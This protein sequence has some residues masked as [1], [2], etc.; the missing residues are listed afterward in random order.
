MIDEREL[1]V[2]FEQAADDYD[3]P[4]DGPTRILAAAEAHAPKA[5][6]SQRRRLA[7]GFAVIV[8]VVGATVTIRQLTDQQERSKTAFS[9]AHSGQTAP[10]RPVSAPPSSGSGTAAAMPAGDQGASGGAAGSGGIAPGVANGLA[11]PAP[12]LVPQPST[13]STADSAK[14]VK[15]GSLQI[16]VRRD[17]VRSTMSSLVSAANGLGGYAADT[18]TSEGADNPTGTLTLRVP[19]ASFDDLIARVRSIGDVRSST[20]H[21]QD[22]TG[23][24]TDIQARL[25]AL[26]ATRGQLLTILQRASAIGDVLAV[27]DRLND[28][29]SQIDQLQGQQKVLDDQTSYASLS[30][31]ISQ[32]GAKPSVPDN[33]S[34]LARAWQD[35]RHG[36]TSGVEDILAASGT[37]LVVLLVLAAIA[38][39]GRY[40]W[41][42][43]RRRLV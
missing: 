43:V 20:T 15:T 13:P 5:P 32:R 4:A 22:V 10:P 36:F 12:P 28:V 2:L 18:R 8:V 6:W 41:L 38:V 33:P 16:E 25:A 7:V 31:D 17:A 11:G 19:A 9:T 24:Y 1:T 26:N 14:V 23:Q 21:G 3:V 40:V 37:T 34:G 27:Q 30:V 42:L 29:Q 39:I 35:A